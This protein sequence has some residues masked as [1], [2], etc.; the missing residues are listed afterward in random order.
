MM[1]FFVGA[2][3]VLLLLNRMLLNV[4][5]ILFKINGVYFRVI[6]G[7][8]ERCLISP[9]CGVADQCTIFGTPSNLSSSTTSL[10]HVST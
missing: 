5:L 7:D 2:D 4:A 10:V 1:A 8:T 3:R 9:S 6:A